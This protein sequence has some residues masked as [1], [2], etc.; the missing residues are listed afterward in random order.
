[1]SHRI[2]PL[3]LIPSPGSKEQAHEST[4]LQTTLKY[5]L[6]QAFSTL[7]TTHSTSLFRVSSFSACLP[8]P[9]HTKSLIHPTQ[10]NQVNRIELSNSICAIINLYTLNAHIKNIVKPKPF[11]KHLGESN[12]KRKIE[13]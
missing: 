11:V 7:D 9:L 2:N 5:I 1:M 13:S 3:N 8:S 12:L 10:A 6:H 4:L